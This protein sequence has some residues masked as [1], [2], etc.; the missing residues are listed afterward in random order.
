MK[1]AVWKGDDRIHDGG[2]YTNTTRDD[3][4][5][6]KRL[7]TFYHYHHHYKNANHHQWTARRSKLRPDSITVSGLRNSVSFQFIV[8]DRTFLNMYP[9]P[10]RLAFWNVLNAKSIPKSSKYLC[11]YCHCFQS[12]PHYRYHYYYGTRVWH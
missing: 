8:Y 3:V 2:A 10:S 4:I 5:K 11:P 12:S 9:V 6:T 1:I 7:K